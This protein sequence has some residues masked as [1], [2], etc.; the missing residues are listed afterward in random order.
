MCSGIVYGW[1]MSQSLS[2]ILVH[3]VFSTKNREPWLTKSLRSRAFAYLAEVG[4]DQGC[5][6]YR[7]GGV[8]DHV[9]LAVQLSRTISAAEF[10]KK[11]KQSSSVWIKEHGGNHSEEIGESASSLSVGPPMR[12]EVRGPIGLSGIAWAASGG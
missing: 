7:V 6:V 10:V 4:R 8:A 12:T 3:L 2:R 11:V 1:Q 5:E 9:H